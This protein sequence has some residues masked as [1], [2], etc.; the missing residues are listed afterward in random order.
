MLNM[1][2]D[3]RKKGFCWH[4]GI[5]TGTFE[6]KLKNGRILNITR[7]DCGLCNPHDPQK[8]FFRYRVR[9]ITIMKNMSDN[10]IFLYECP[11]SNK[12]KVAHHPDYTKPNEI[13]LL[14]YLCHS[15]AH[16]KKAA[17][18]QSVDSGF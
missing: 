12:R 3:K 7:W 18:N 6:R 5:K 10:I 13:E 14:C 8:D 9:A 15:K 16:R 4:C 17:R 11:C 2:M 1:N